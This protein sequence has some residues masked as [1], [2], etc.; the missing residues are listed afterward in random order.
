MPIS[1]RSCSKIRVKKYIYFYPP[2]FLQYNSHSHQNEIKDVKL[3]FFCALYTQ[4]ER[5]YL[6]LS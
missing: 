6:I 4:K 5:N 3:F 1:Q 2:Y